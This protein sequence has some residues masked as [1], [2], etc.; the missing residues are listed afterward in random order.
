MSLPKRV[1]ICGQSIFM[2]AFQALLTNRPGLEVTPFSPYTP[3]IVERLVETRPDL[4]LMEQN[5]HY[6]QFILNLLEEGLPL[7]EL[8]PQQG[9]AVFLVGRKI[10]LGQ[11]TDLTELLE[12]LSV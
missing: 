12:H 4:I 3:E 6:S 11:V 10:V 9:E 1:F 8:A 5:S 7:L 2:E